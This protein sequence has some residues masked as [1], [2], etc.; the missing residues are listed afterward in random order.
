MDDAAS[1]PVVLQM[2]FNCPQSRRFCNELRDLVVETAFVFDD[3]RCIVFERVLNL[4]VFAMVI[5][6]KDHF[7]CV[8]ALRES[9]VNETMMPCRWH[10][11]KMVEI[12]GHLFLFHPVSH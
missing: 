12:P 11:A 7:F 5:L 2:I 4:K 6:G 3:R 10:L 8:Q 1:K 9:L